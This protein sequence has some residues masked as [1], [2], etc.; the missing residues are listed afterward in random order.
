MNRIGKLLLLLWLQ[1]ELH[2]VEDNEAIR[3]SALS[4]FRPI[5]LTSVTTIAGLAPLIFF[6]K[7]FQA[8][9]LVPMAITVAYGLVLATYTT[10]ILV[11]VLLIVLNWVRVH[12]VWVWTGEKPTKEEV[13]PAVREIKFETHEHI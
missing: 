4:R 8:Q 10:L 6:E 7:S 3:V 1:Q 2:A 5:I 9:F 12:V 11:P 13:E